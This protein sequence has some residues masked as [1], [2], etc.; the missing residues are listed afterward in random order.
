MLK[1]IIRNTQISQLNFLPVQF[2]KNKN[3]H[4]IFPS[5]LQC[6]N[7]IYEKRCSLEITKYLYEKDCPIKRINLDYN[8]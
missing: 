8:N 7:C 1:G 6:L 2:R 5:K 4:Y 3:I